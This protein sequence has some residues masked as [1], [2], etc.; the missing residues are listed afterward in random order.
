MLS[1][2]FL[3]VASLTSD[4]RVLARGDGDLAGL[5][6]GLRHAGEA[7]RPNLRPFAPHSFLVQPLQAKQKALELGNRRLQALGGEPMELRIAASPLAHPRRC[8][9]C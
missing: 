3:S 9:C 8:R 5:E 7:R 4:G 2:R 1:L 6:M